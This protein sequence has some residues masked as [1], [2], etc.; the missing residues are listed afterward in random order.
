MDSSAVIKLI[1]LAILLLLS[2]FFSSAE[3]VLTTVNVHRLRHLSENGNKRAAIVLAIKDDSSKMLTAILIV[4]NVVNLSASALTTSL[5][6]AIGGYMI[7]L[8]TGVLTLF[9]LIFGEITPKTLATIYAEPLALAYSSP[10]FI[11]MKLLTPFIFVI[12][13]I[14][15]GILML[16]RI[17]PNIKNNAITETELRTIVDVS[18][19]DG[20]IESEDDKII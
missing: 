20:M 6:Y 18:H 8:A 7:G 14:S 16:F 5:A 15:L 12:N 17:D 4:N 1:S 13:G 11:T 10:I 3:T 2:A 9:I 19:E